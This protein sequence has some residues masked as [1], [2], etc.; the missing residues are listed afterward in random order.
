MRR[1]A[2]LLIHRWMNQVL[3]E[4]MIMQR[5]WRNTTRGMRRQWRARSDSVRQ[6]R[7]PRMKTAS[8]VASAISGMRQAA[9]WCSREVLWHSFRGSQKKR[10]V[11]PPEVASFIILLTRA[12]SHSKSLP[13]GESSTATQNDCRQIRV[14]C[15]I[16]SIVF[17]SLANWIPNFRPFEW[18]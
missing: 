9:E 4:I 10:V 11:Y 2:F 17:V 14:Y 16:M 1:F 18:V 15:A 7:R 3:H 12:V 8:F 13:A 6:K 5:K